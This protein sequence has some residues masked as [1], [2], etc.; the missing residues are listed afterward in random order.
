MRVVTNSYFPK[1]F[2]GFDWSFWN[3]QRYFMCLCCIFSEFLTNVSLKEA[4]M[5]LSGYFTWKIYKWKHYKNALNGPLQKFM[6]Q[7]WAVTLN[8]I[9][10]YCHLFTLLKNPKYFYNNLI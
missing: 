3:S 10:Q 9:S 7:T 5:N 2:Q 8:F 6:N 1:D 4:V